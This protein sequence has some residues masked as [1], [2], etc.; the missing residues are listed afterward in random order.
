[1]NVEDIIKFF[2]KVSNCVPIFASRIFWFPIILLQC[3][4]ENINQLLLH[5]NDIYYTHRLILNSF[6]LGVILIILFWKGNYLGSLMQFL[7]SFVVLIIIYNIINW[8]IHLVNMPQLLVIP[9]IIK[10]VF[11]CWMVD[12]FIRWLIS[13]FCSPKN[14]IT[15]H[16]HY[17]RVITYFV[18]TIIYLILITIIAVNIDNI[19]NIIVNF[20]V[21]SIFNRQIFNLNIVVMIYL[22]YLLKEIYKLNRLP[23]MSGFYGLYHKL[24]CVKNYSVYGTLDTVKLWGAF[25]VNFETRRELAIIGTNSNLSTVIDKIIND[26]YMEITPLEA[27][28]LINSHEFLTMLNNEVKNTYLADKVY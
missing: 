21:E 1:M 28:L 16:V 7:G 22:I 10:I 6:A 27:K 19:K 18:L 17:V 15:T 25:R 11:I 12:I 4:T 23:S 24:K 3:G 20:K 13:N 9:T 14:E 26:K 8:A 5:L 2:T